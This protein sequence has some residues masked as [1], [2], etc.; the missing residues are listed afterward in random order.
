[1]GWTKVLLDGDVTG[2]SHT[3]LSA[4]HTDTVAAAVVR[5][6]L[7][8]G[9]STPAWARVAG[10]ANAVPQ[11]TTGGDTAWTTAPRLANIADTGGT[12]RITTATTASPG[13][14]VTLTGGVQISSG[15]VGIGTAPT[16]GIAFNV[17][18]NP[19][20][21]TANFTAAQIQPSVATIGATGLSYYALGGIPQVLVGTGGYTTSKITAL[22]FLLGVAAG[23]GTA[24]VTEASCINVGM[25]FS[26][27]PNMTVTDAIGLHFSSM[28]FQSPGA[29]MSVA[30]TTGVKIANIATSAKQVN[31]IGVDIAAFGTLPTG[32]KVG[33]RNANPT[34]F[35]PSTAQTLAAGTAILANATVV[36]IISTGNVTS[37]A[38]PT[39]ADGQDGQLLIIIN[40][41]TADTITLSDQGTLASSNLRLSAATIALAPRDNLI[42]VYN[43]TIGDWVQVGVSNVI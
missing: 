18:V 37:T 27:S 15:N 19:G 8:I 5:G 26:V 43:S 36:Q 24:I 29:S 14:N 35:T 6:D 33:I 32:F 2:G 9:N 13:P 10:V 22:N 41:D 34:V 28:T 16:A 25:L 23:S 31:V 21:L 30:T 39:V 3:I 42:L 7:M 1:M 17:G 38:A 40:V 4:T 20:T 12:N 11:F